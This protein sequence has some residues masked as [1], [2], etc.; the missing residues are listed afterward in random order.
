MKVILVLLDGLGDRTYARLGHKTPLAAARSPNLDR[1]AGMGANGTYH[2]LAPGHCLPSEMAHFLMFGYDLADFPGRGLLEAVGEKV[3]FSDSDV[4]VL[5]HLCGV[6]TDKNQKAFLE[7]GRDDIPG[8][9]HFLNRFY[10]QISKY[11]YKK[12]D[13]RLHQTGRNDAI[14]VIHGDVSPDISDSDPVRRKSPIARV[15]PLAGTK[16]PDRAAKTADALN[17]YLAWCADRLKAPKADPGAR[18]PAVVPNFLA[19]QRAGRRKPIA[20]F[21]EKWGFSPAMIASG[22]VYQGLAMELGFDFSRVQDSADPGKDLAERI[23]TAIDDPDY[24]FIHVHTKVPDQ[25]SHRQT[26]ERKA[27]VISEL[28]KGFAGLLNLLETGEKDILAVVTADHSTPSDSELIHSGETVPLA[29]AGGAIRKDMVC[30]FDE[31]AAAAGSLGQL[32]GADLMHM[33]LN[34]TDRAMLQGLCLGAHKRAYRSENYPAFTMD[35][36]KGSR[37]LS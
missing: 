19:T 34:S 24:D 32:R 8:D 31:I 27:E 17:H 12:I 5:A 13:F 33:I 18:K 23:R 7:H 29:M 2:A 28:D 10:K 11:E 16:E 26:P 15:M 4:L 14:L 22:G 3:P 35:K 1:I 6:G 21:E 36:Q 30:R 25:V 37:Q 9:R 20:G